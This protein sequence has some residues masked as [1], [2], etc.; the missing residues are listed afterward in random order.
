MAQP[1]YKIDLHTYAHIP[2]SRTYQPSC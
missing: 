1:P 2:Q